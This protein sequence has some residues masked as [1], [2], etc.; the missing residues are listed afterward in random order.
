M[1]TGAWLAPV[2]GDAVDGSMFPETALP[3]LFMVLRRARNGRSA[4]AQLRSNPRIP[5][6]DPGAERRTCCA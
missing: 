4:T 6:L 5:G 2:T 3:F 1:N